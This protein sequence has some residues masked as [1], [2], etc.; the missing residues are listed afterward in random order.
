[1]G[2]IIL[3][4]YVIC[5]R[6][7]V[8]GE[9][10]V[11]TLRPVERRHYDGGAA[12]IARHI[13][14]M[15]GRPILV[16]ALPGDEQADAIR[17]RLLAE[18]VE[19]RWIEADKPLTEKQRFLVGAQKIMKVDLCEPLVLDATR[20]DHLIALAGEAAGDAGGANAAII[21]DFGQ[22]LLT[23]GVLTRLCRALRQRV[24]VLAGDV[25]GRRS[26]LRL[27]RSM[28]LICPS[29]AELREAYGMFDEGLPTVV[30]S[31]LKETSA[32]AAVVTMGAEGL[33]AFDRLPDADAAG[34]GF[35]S[36]VRGEH[37][38]A[39]SPF[40]IDALGCGDSLLAAAALAL[41]AGG[42]LLSATFLGS[43]AAAVQAQR[44]GNVPVS[45]TDLR[46]GIV[47]VHNA[48]LAYAS[49]EVVTSRSARPP[50]E[51]PA[52]SLRAS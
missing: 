47:R 37:V 40:A 34:D 43:V 1:V 28:D 4:T 42:T 33:I 16:T 35:R 26:G 15:G 44:I 27:M 7:D 3:D 32:R 31:L 13:A 11:M 9:S 39:L 41:A 6:P 20:Q 50:P 19:V 36:R 29:E 24:A 21:A 30:W 14:A 49:P 12:I 52:A 18:G 45:A 51:S 46:H 22:G 5:D 8:A 2:E 23:A 48:H 25:S 17:R 10:P 38:P